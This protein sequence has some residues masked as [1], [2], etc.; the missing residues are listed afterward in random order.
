MK[1]FSFVLVIKILNKLYFG[2]LNFHICWKYTICKLLLM[3]LY[4]GV[5]S[6]TPGMWSMTY[7]YFGNSPGHLVFRMS[8]GTVL[9]N[10]TLPC[11]DEWSLY[12]E[13]FITWTSSIAF[14]YPPKLSPLLVCRQYAFVFWPSLQLNTH[15]HT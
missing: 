7:N 14:S 15:T 2:W 9:I 1:S 11:F 6:Y 4:E 5:F 12:W 10:S 3:F 13:C 8:F